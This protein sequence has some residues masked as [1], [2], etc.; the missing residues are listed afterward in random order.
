MIRTFAM[1]TDIE[2]AIQ[3]S[4][5][6][7]HNRLTSR[8]ISR[9]ETINVDKIFEKLEVINEC[10][11]CCDDDKICIKCFQCTAYYCKDCLIKIAS[12][13][14]KCSTCN[15]EL[16]NNYNKIK[17]Y[18][19]ELQEIVQYEKAIADSIADSLRKVSINTNLNTTNLNTTNLNTTNLNTTNLNTTN[20]NTTNLNTTISINTPNNLNRYNDIIDR[21]KQ[22]LN[23]LQNDKIYYINFNSY[24]SVVSNTTPNYHYEYDFDNKSI[25][26]FT[27]CNNNKDFNNIIIRY[28]IINIKFQAEFYAWI[29]TILKCSFTVFKKKWNSIAN[30]V[31]NFNTPNATDVE[32]QIL[33]NDIIKICK[34]K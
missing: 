29:N 10:L 3:I 20:L 15:V 25:V 11:I 23:D 33:I 7:E 17:I 18:N 32:I 26:F 28:N 9:T 8:E 12:E 19:E 34:E 30:K 24:V 4:F 5:N 21:K 27:L 14:N 2:R 22:F 13:F 16:K 6:D 1:A 31:N